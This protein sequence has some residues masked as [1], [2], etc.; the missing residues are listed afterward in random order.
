[1]W[2]KGILL[3]VP[4]GKTASLCVKTGYVHTW[5]RKSATSEQRK[6]KIR[7]CRVL[8]FV[9]LTQC[10]IL[11]PGDRDPLTTSVTRNQTRGAGIVNPE[12]E[13]GCNGR[14]TNNI[15]VSE[16]LPAASESTSRWDNRYVLQHYCPACNGVGLENCH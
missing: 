6:Q 11:D 5:L 4:K 2:L 1:M 13:R 3:V 15:L 9:V 8:L 14:H 12:R 10:R 7:N 16:V